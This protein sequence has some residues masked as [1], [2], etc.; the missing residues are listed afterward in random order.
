MRP[1]RPLSFVLST[2]Y[3]LSFL[4]VTAGIS[5][6]SAAV[7]PWMTGDFYSPFPFTA[8]FPDINNILATMDFDPTVGS[9]TWTWV[10]DPVQCTGTANGPITGGGVTGTIF[11]SQSMFSGAVTGGAYHEVEYVDAITGEVF[12]D[13]QFYNYTF[14]GSWSNGWQSIGGASAEFEFY[15]RPDSNYDLTTYVPEPGT[16]TLIGMGVLALRFRFRRRI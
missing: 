2:V 14:T 6:A 12:N 9:V 13:L 15:A 7:V 4:F 16:C 5:Q 11:A 3:L 10:C 8:Y 1:R